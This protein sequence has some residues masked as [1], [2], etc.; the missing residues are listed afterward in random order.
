MRRLITSTIIRDIMKKI[1]IIGGTTPESTIYYYRTFLELSR[2]L[3]EPNFYP[4][5][6]IYSLNFKD[7]SENP[8]GWE[9]RKRMLIQA[10]QALEK[11]GAEIIAISANTPHIV[12]DDVQKNVK[13]KMISIIDALTEE[14]NRRGLKTLLLLGTKTT[15]S[16]P[17]YKDSLQKHGIKTIVPNEDEMDRI[18]EIIMKELS[19]GNFKSKEYVIE[20]IDKYAPRV[21][22]VILG[23]TELPL[24]VKDYDVEIPVLDTA[25]IHVKKILEEAIPSKPQF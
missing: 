3:F 14:A 2:E 23:C 9:G 10:A 16:M 21:D 7:F 18:N 11:A 25:K 20:L 15:M 17:F 22:G 12:F 5:I 24:I 13:A 8:D 19:M 4:Y 6:I 1:G